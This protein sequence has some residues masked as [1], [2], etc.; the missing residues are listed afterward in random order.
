MS[1]VYFAAIAFYGFHMEATDHTFEC[2]RRLFQPEA[3][4]QYFSESIA[5]HFLTDDGVALF[6]VN[7]D[8]GERLYCLSSRTSFISDYHLS[9]PRYVG[10][11]VPFEGIDN[12]DA[13]HRYRNQLKSLGVSDLSPITYHHALEVVSSK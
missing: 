9:S 2:L 12:Y 1:K 13:L 5:G 7:D 10:G 3:D 4:N 6:S 8:K 11:I